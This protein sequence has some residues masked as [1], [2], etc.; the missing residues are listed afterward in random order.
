MGAFIGIMKERQGG[1]QD[2]NAENGY[3][4]SPSSDYSIAD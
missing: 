2:E 1:K 3:D 4:G